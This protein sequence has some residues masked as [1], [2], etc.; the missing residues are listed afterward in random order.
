MMVV[1]VVFGGDGCVG[2]GVVI[3]VGCCC[4]CCC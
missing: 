3:V 2:S 1:D 4:C